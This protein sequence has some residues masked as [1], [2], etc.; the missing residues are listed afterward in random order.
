MSITP[1]RRTAFATGLREL[2]DFIEANPELPIPRSSTVIHYFPQQAPD[3][4]MCTEI[5][6]IAEILGT[7]IDPDH[8][9]H[10]HYTTSRCFGPIS[11]EA[12]A[13]LADARARHA[14]LSSYQDCVTPDTDTAHAA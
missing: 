13:I 7:E 14:A 1:D 2:A 12:A 3:A 8:L 6:R 9:P 11:Y 4:E 10:G 5:D